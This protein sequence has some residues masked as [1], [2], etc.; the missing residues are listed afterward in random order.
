MAPVLSFERGGLM[1]FQ[2]TTLALA[3]GA[4]VALSM[5]AAPAV[6]QGKAKAKARTARPSAV[7]NQTPNAPA[8]AAAPEAEKS[9]KVDISDIENKYWAPKDTD[10]SVVQNRTYTKEG[11]FGLALQGGLLVNDGYSDGT[12]YGGTVNYF[13]SERYG[14]EA[15]YATADVHENDS[16]K[17][18]IDYG[19]GIKPDYGRMQN[20]Y[21]VAF[22]WIP[23]Y[24]KMSVLGK[25]IIYFDMAFS[26]A[27]GMMNY[28]QV[29]EGGGLDKSAMAYG[30][31][32]TQYFFLS[33]NF[34][35][36]VDLRNRWFKEDVAKYYTSDG[37][38]MGTT[39]RNKTTTNTQLLFGVNFFF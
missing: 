35:L 34:S 15:T 2:N 5:A 8:P 16:T 3:T 22:N 25:K 37:I 36:R 9:D 33:K 29:T 10:F 20:Y 18:L 7:K 30:F 28:E 1:R 12:V 27:I 13:F 14:V 19:G 17:R 31:D 26:P 23:F 21:G 11:K 39:F 6:A 32:V 4:L 38:S 24:A